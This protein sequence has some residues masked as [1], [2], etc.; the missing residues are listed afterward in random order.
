MDEWNKVVDDHDCMDWKQLQ[1]DMSYTD[2]C[3]MQYHQAHVDS[4]DYFHRCSYLDMMM[5]PN[6]L[7][8]YAVT[9][10]NQRYFQPNQFAGKKR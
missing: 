10:K 4:M 2:Y 6:E 8:P 7:M 1:D 5:V 3:R 9:R